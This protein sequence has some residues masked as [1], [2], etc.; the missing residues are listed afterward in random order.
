MNE[1]PVVHATLVFE[2]SVTATTEQVFSAYADPGR[3]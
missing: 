3:S 1:T 2:R